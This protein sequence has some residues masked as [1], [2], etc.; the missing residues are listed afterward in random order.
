MSVFQLSFYYTD[1]S[2][3]TTGKKR[4]EELNE[5][6][7]YWS[8]AVVRMLAIVTIF[9]ATTST[10]LDLVFQVRVAE[11]LVLRPSRLTSWGH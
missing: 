1:G 10:L 7:K 9:G 11:H 5:V 4:F 8:S 2:C 3:V 6:G